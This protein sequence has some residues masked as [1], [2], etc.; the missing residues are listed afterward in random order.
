[1]KVN[2]LVSEIL[3][4]IDKV[5]EIDIADMSGDTLSRLAVRLASYKAG[6]GAYVAQAHREARQ[7][8]A[9]YYEVRA[10]E[11]KRLREEE[12][13]GSGDADELKRLGPTKEALDAWNEAQYR[14]DKLS[15]LSINIHDIIESVK[16]RIIGLQ[17]ERRESNVF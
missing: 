5:N 1:M 16:T 17:A 4:I 6:L 2:E 8:E 12:G 10:E 3:T 7:A 9:D 11:Y 13:R 15:Q 14:A